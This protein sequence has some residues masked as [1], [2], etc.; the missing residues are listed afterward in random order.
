M[1]DV[2]LGPVSRR[3][4]VGSLVAGA[5]ALA[6]GRVAA[7]DLIALNVVGAPIDDFKTVQYGAKTGVFARHGLKVEIMMVNSGAAGLAAVAGGAA[8]VALSSMPAIMQGFLRAVPFRIVAPAQLY[9]TDAPAVVLLVKK[10]GPIR[11]AADLNGKTIAGASLKDLNSVTTLA[12][13][14]RNGGDSSTVK[15]VEMP[16]SSA[17]P[18]LEDGRIDA[19]PVAAPYFDQALATGKVRVLTKPYDVIG[20][21]FEATAY[22]ALQPWIEADAAAAERFARAMHELIVFTNAHQSETVDLVASYSG[23]D[24]AVV[25]KSVRSVDPEYVEAA[26]LQ[27]LIDFAANA[28]VIDRRFD[29]NEIIAST[30]LRPP[31]R[32]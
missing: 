14:D 32:R 2:F 18:S 8:N 31:A 9:L 11:T 17:V 1:R 16:L 13:I 12:W 28:R 20:K 30:A 7:Q 4:A 6:H 26:N 24:A 10:D 22:V 27:P 15:V 19:F 25:A 23:V 21:R 29:A 5:V 3:A